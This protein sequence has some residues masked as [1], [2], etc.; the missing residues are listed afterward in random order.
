MSCPL[1]GCLLTSPG[2]R[3]NV[4]SRGDIPSR[5]DVPSSSLLAQ[6]LQ[7]AVAGASGIEKPVTGRSSAAPSM[8]ISTFSPGFPICLPWMAPLYTREPPTA[9]KSVRRPIVQLLR[10]SLRLALTCDRLEPLRSGHSSH[11]AP[12]LCPFFAQGGFVALG[13]ASACRH[14]QRPD[15]P[16]HVAEEPPGQMPVRAGVSQRTMPKRCGGITSRPTRAR[17]THRATSGSCMPSAGVS[18]KTTTRPICGPTSPQRS[19][20]VQTGRGS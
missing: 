1:H 17:P 15:P 19:P 20:P 11:T 10:P 9:Q 16:Q 4:T 7:A 6:K 12:H 3:G 14:R 13:R 2:C 18:L 8:R 5:S